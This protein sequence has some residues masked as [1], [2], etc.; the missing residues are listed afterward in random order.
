MLGV[1][2]ALGLGVDPHRLGADD[3][4]HDVE[5]VWSEVDDDPDVADPRRERAEPRGAD[6]EDAAE[7]PPPKS[8]AQLADRRIEALDVADGQHSPGRGGGL[9]HR[10]GLLAGR[11][12]RLLDEHV[13]ARAKRRER[14]R[15]VEAGR[16]DDADE[17]ELLLR[18]HP[19]RVL[20]PA[21][22]TPGGC[23]STGAWIGI[24]DRDQVDPVDE[25]V[26]DPDVVAAH[27]PQT[28]HAGAQRAL[29]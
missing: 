25:L 13:G 24:G 1:D 8:A 12:D 17:V 19:L 29:R 9:D 22:A 28:H 26:P 2:A 20:E 18:Q 7:L 4:P 15:E 27:H 23:V 11:R 3:E 14:R 5:I 16:R 10:L 6:L 21:S